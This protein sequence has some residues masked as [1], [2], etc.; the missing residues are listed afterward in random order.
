MMQ[1]RTC[2]IDC[3][4]WIWLT[5]IL[6]NTIFLPEPKA[7]GVIHWGT[8]AIT[9]EKGRCQKLILLASNVLGPTSNFS[10]L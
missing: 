4:I 3:L 1:I 5:Q 9:V 10:A 2:C 8:V 6:L 7:V